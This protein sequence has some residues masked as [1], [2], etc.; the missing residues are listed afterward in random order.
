MIKKSLFFCVALT[1]TQSLFCNLDF[2]KQ[3]FNN[4]RNNP[5]EFY[6]YKGFNEYYQTVQKNGLNRKDFIN[7]S[8]TPAG[9]TYLVYSGAKYVLYGYFA[10]K[11]YQYMNP[12]EKTA[13]GTD[14]PLNVE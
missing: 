12:S 13:D 4:L 14:N 11:S 8:K 9:K 2:I 10:Y 7:F 6:M 5:Y 3:E 1:M